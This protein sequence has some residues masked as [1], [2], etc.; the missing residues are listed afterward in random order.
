MVNAKNEAG[1]QSAVNLQ[2]AKLYIQHSD[3]QI[4]TRSWQE[5]MDKMLK[6]KRDASLERWR[7]A[8]AENK[9]FN[10]L[11]QAYHL[12]HCYHHEPH[13]MLA[14]MLVLMLGFLLFTVFAQL[15]SPLV[16]L[17][18]RTLE[19]LAHELDLALEED[20]PWNQWFHSG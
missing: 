11:T 9:A 5:V 14:Q 19:A 15:H 13:A 1:R 16:R 6:T 4:G 8:V 3:P 10:E 7:V 17:G 20:L 18:Q 2:I 12:E